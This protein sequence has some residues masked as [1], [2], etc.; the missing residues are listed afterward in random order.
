M[1][2]TLY[3]ITRLNGIHTS[4]IIMTVIS[5]FVV[6][7]SCIS[8]IGSKADGD[9]DIATIGANTLKLS[10]LTLIIGTLII[11]FVPTTKEALLIYGV[12]NT[13]EYIKSNEKAQQLPDK[14]I[15]ALDAWVEE[16]NKEETK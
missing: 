14:C 5:V 15:D 12:G 10:T 11:V 3:W 7:F 13:I 1:I 4:G 2:E 6:V 8:Y 9:D 16:L